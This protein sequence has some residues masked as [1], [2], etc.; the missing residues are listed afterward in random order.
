MKNKKIK[1]V[2]KL[3]SLQLFNLLNSVL[4]IKFSLIKSLFRVEKE[5][6]LENVY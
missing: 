3:K 4:E 5:R 1:I 6:N 2:F